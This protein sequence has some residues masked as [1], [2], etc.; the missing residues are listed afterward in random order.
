MNKQ[1]PHSTA[2]VPPHPLWKKALFGL[3]AG[4]GNLVTAVGAVIA[5]AVLGYMF[6]SG[7]GDGFIDSFKPAK[8]ARHQSR[9]RPRLFVT[10]YRHQERQKPFR[11][12][13]V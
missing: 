13:E 1:C 7:L 8:P 5:A 10:P 6:G 2:A 11:G 3:F 12:L 4:I 9:P